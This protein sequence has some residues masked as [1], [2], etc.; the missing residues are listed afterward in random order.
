MKKFEKG[1]KK[2]KKDVEEKGR[3]KASDDYVERRMFAKKH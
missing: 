3:Q 2:R 1:D